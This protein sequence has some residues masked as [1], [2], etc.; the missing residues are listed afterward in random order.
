[1]KR[2][3]LLAASCAAILGGATPAF[4]ESTLLTSR[5][6][7]GSAAPHV[8]SAEDARRYRT[9]FEDERSGNFAAARQEIAELSDRCL[10]GYV[11]AEHYLSHKGRRTPVTELA[12]WLEK[13]DELPIAPEVRALAEKRERRHHRVAL[14][15]IPE[16]HAR[17]GWGYE[18]AD[19]VREVPL[20]SD[21]ARSAQTQIEQDVRADQ[22]AQAEA[23]L[24]TLVASGTTPSSDI[25]RLT[26]R[27]AA[28]YLAEGM[29]PDAW[30]VANAVTLN[31]REAAPLLDWDAGL[32][33]YRQSNFAD[34]A[35]DFEALAQNG[36]V[37]GWARSAGAFWAARAYLQA[38]EPLKVVSLLTAAA[39]EQPT[40]YGLLAERL[41]GQQSQ[42]DFREPMLDSA[43]FESMMQ[44]PAAHRAV[45]LWQV[46]ESAYVQPEMLRAFAG[47]SSSE[48]SAFAALA[49]RMDLPDLE[50]RA[51]ETQAQH[52]VMLSGLFPMP[53]YTPPGGY[54]V[55]PCLVLA[56]ARVESRFEAK[57]VSHAGA[58]GVM[59]IMPGT[60]QMVDDAKPRKSQLNDPAYSLG[61]GQKYLQG[62]LDQVNGNLFQLAAAY[63]AG[64]GALTHWIG[65]RPSITNDPLLFIES[66]PVQETRNY[67][68]RVMTFYW[69]YARRAG[70]GAPSLEDAAEGKWPVY[71]SHGV[72]VATP[73][74]VAGTTLVS[75][76]S[77]PH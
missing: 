42:S 18:T 53:R 13:Y 57:A 44:V 45:A 62:L 34:A 43:G 35:A 56:F 31:D 19:T 54:Q 67:I 70:K 40:F 16:V 39:R 28:S 38:G 26:H 55:D 41:L 17:G 63:N 73:P 8:L 24:Q 15:A 21:A 6:D 2:P 65:A 20:S 75:D 49:H 59:Q 3:L 77:I 71:R 29:D 74:A 37:T 68:K 25:A 61:I 51:S 9:I 7:T 46:G 76:A 60:A 69:L 33:A 4:S 72:P 23:V 32:A 64:P 47:V 10:M 48:T 1:M 5:E 36:S 11:E 27:V 58:R 66:I 22:P 14:A 50:L 52:G 30:R 12:A